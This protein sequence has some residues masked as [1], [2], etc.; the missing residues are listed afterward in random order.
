MTPPFAYRE[1]W[2]QSAIEH[3]RRRCYSPVGVVIP[4]VRAATSWPDKGGTGKRHRVT[5][6]CWLPIA[7]GDGIPQVCISPL[8]VD[9]IDVLG[10]LVHECIHAARPESGHGP[11]F[12]SVAVKVGL[13]GKMTQTKVGPDLRVVLQDIA[14]ELGPYPHREIRLNDGQFWPID[15][16]P[17]Q[18]GRLIKVICPDCGYPAH[19]TRIWLGKLGPPFCPCGRQMEI[20]FGHKLFK[21]TGPQV[22]GHA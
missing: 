22:D 21:S 3:G 4:D 15:A 1:D 20:D 16:R 19:V 5:G 18:I 11:G 8:L 14:D 13:V 6:Q 7:T 10:T 12:R 9:P 2:L 17:K